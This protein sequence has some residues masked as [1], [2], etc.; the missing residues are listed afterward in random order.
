MKSIRPP[1]VVIF[2]MT[3]RG[4]GGPAPENW[5][6]KSG[7]CHLPAGSRVAN[8]IG[9]IMDQEDNLSVRTEQNIYWFHTVVLE[10]LAK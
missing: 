9:R 5:N 6:R 7:A 3:G 10:I 2:F 1:S 8:F 4:G